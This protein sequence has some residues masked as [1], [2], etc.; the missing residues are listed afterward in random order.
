[1][2]SQ[3]INA[4]VKGR[5]KARIP[6]LKQ[7]SSFRDQESEPRESEDE[8]EYYEDSTP[9]SALQYSNSNQPQDEQNRVIL[10]S[11]D[12]EYNGLFGQ[13][14][15]STRSRADINRPVSRTTSNIARTKDVQKETIQTI[16]NYSKVNDDGSFTFG[17]LFDIIK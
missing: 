14:T 17:N 11:N 1:M 10:V 5:A 6:T 9:E 8:R 12:D 3:V 16:R 4:Q 13:P 2:L 15:P 7:Q